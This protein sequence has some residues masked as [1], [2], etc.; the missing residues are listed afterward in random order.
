MS[1]LNPMARKERDS[2]R[3]PIRVMLVD[4]SRVARS[5]FARVLGS[6][7]HIVITAEA[8][9][10]EQALAVLGSTE[11]DVILLDIE[12]PKRTGLEALPDILIASGG[13]RIIVVSS[14]V[15]KNGPAALQAL[16]LGACD[17]LAKIGD[18]E[19]RGRFSEL[20]REKVYRLGRR[21]HVSGPLIAN[22]VPPSDL[23]KP[24]CIAIG[25]STGGIPI[26]YD[27]VSKLPRQLDCPIF[28]AQHLP[29]AFME[30]FAK[31]LS[32]HTSRNVSVVTKQCEVEPGNIY[33]APGN[34]HLVCRRIGD[35]FTLD[36][37]RKRDASHYCPSVDVLFHSVA[38]VYGSS[39]IAII[40]SGMGKDGTEGARSLAAIGASILVQDAQSSVVWGMPGSV[41]RENIP[42][43]IMTPPAMSKLLIKTF[44]S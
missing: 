3:A 24:E 41:V 35:K 9:N 40:L 32:A 13:A 10:P 26:L 22:N 37:S 14:F 20:L 23:S 17:T 2:G 6:C 36:L 33:L 4:D 43:S 28:I 42:A 31:Q 15:E 25:A 18:G 11:V 5:I 27:L 38:E 19:N 34:A 29:M 1:A 21:S 7:D 16:S 39:A 8:E 30:F 12:M 44:Q